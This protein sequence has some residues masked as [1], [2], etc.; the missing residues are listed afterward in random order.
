MG[1]KIR[2]SGQREKAEKAVAAVT[3]VAVAEKKRVVVIDKT[4]GSE[5]HVKGAA[6]LAEQISIIKGAAA[7]VGLGFVRLGI[8]LA[9]VKREELWRFAT[10]P[11]ESFAAWAERELGYTRMSIGN[12]IAVGEC[13]L[14]PESI[15]KLGPSVAYVV[16]RAPDGQAREELLALAKR[17]RTLAELKGEA[18]K[19]RKARGI[20]PRSPGRPKKVA[21]EKPAPKAKGKLTLQ[22]V[23]GGGNP[24][25]TLP[26][27]KTPS[28]KRASV[29]E[30]LRPIFPPSTAGKKGCTG[31]RSYAVVLLD[32]IKLIITVDPVDETVTVERV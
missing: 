13:G 2:Q 19:Q 18:Q 9:R 29:T 28:A 8:A 15:G 24:R 25:A 26:E 32:E 31:G 10:P 27:G 20:V 21:P 1:R 4:P 11:A 5:A 6:R 17:G 12:L 7:D 23:D 3:A 16:A 30:K 14:P 22:V